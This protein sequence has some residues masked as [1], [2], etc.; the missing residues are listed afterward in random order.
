MSYLSEVLRQGSSRDYWLRRCL[1]FLRCYWLPNWSH[2]CRRLL[3]RLLDCAGTF[4]EVVKK[5][6]YKSHTRCEEKDQACVA[7]IATEPRRRLILVRA[8]G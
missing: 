7:L 1:V 2:C 8:S 4:R 3:R 5:G 6:S